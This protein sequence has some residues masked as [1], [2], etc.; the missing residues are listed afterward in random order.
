MIR[1]VE[2]E[3]QKRACKPVPDSVVVEDRLEDC[4]DVDPVLLREVPELLDSAGLD[5]QSQRVKQQHNANRVIKAA[6]LHNSTDRHGSDEVS[7]NLVILRFKLFKDL[8]LICC[9]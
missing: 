1:H 6:R 7:H 2:R 3:C 9:Q 4:H 5:D 8:M